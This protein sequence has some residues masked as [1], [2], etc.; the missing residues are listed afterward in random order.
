MHFGAVKDKGAGREKYNCE[1]YKLF[2]EPDIIK[3]TD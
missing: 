2:N 1:L 3:S